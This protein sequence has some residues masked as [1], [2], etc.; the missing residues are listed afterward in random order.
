MN[1]KGFANCNLTGK[2]ILGGSD[3]V[4]WEMIEAF[5]S[6]GAIVQPNWG[7][8]EIGPITINAVF[9]STESIQKVQEQ[10]EYLIHRTPP[11]DFTILGNNY[12]CD[13]KIVGGELHVKGPTCV[14]NDWFATKDMIAIDVYYNMY[15]FG[16]KQ[17]I[18]V[19]RT[20]S[21]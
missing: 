7:M 12:Y 1:T 19:D 5:V 18:S 2:R 17:D 8:S 13:W 4:T 14:H 21:Y 15:Y 9:D 16:R 3:R 11:R 10:S 20:A 6:K